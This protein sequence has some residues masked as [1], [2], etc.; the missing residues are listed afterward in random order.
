MENDRDTS[1]QSWELLTLFLPRF[2]GDHGPPR[3]PLSQN[4]FHHQPFFQHQA[5][6]R[7][8][9]R[10]PFFNAMMPRPMMQPPALMMMANHAAG[11]PPPRHHAPVLK[12]VLPRGAPVATPNPLAAAA[13]PPYPERA[14]VEVERPPGT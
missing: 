11:Q 10:G 13:Y 8:P 5:F 2:R 9:P 7:P 1:L 3:A 12:A 14:D 4:S 6:P